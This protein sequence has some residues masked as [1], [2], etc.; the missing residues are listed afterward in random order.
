MGN[1]TQI[2]SLL[3][4]TVSLTGATTLTK[5]DS[6]KTFI[7]NGATAGAAI[8][9]PSAAKMGNG[10]N[11]KLRVGAAFATTAWTIVAT[12]DIMRGGINELEVDTGSDGPLAS[13]GSGTTMTLVA[14][15]ETVGDVYEFQC[16]G[17]LLFISGQSNLDGG[18]TFA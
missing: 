13:S 18:V 11:F 2:T 10:F 5:A 9:L 15:T 7:L 12:A 1:P 17:T 6:G 4:P 8:T 14:T 16:N 3:I